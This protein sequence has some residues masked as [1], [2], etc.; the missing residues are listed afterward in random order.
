MKNIALINNGCAKNL[1]DSELMLGLLA[2]KGYNITLDETKADIVI[3]NTCSFIHD[4]EKESIQDILKMAM[5]GKKVI[6]TGCLPQKHKMEL[7]KAIPEIIAMLGTSD[8][9]KV[10]DVIEKIEKNP[11][12]FYYEVSDKPEY[13]YPE[14]VSRQ[15]ITVGASSYI[16]I[17]DGCNF[18]CGYCIIPQ[19]RGEYHSRKIEDIVE[20]AKKL[21]DKGVNEIILIAQDTTSYGQDLSGLKNQNLSELI[22]QL[23]KIDSFEWIRI[24]YTYPSFITDEL[25]DIINDSKKVVNYIDMPIQHSHPEVLKSMRRPIIDYRSLISKIRNKVKNVA[26]RTTFIVGYP[27]ETEEQFNHLYNFVNDIK[28]DKLGVFKYSKEENTFAASLGNQISPYIKSKRKKALMELQQKISLEINKSLIGKKIPSIIETITQ[29]NQIIGRT[30]RDAP[31]ID[32]QIYINNTD[33]I[34][35]PGDIVNV[36]VKKADEYDLWGEII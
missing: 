19:L 33:K 7:K 25:L 20:E 34:L 28:F 30:Y 1:V 23:D 6:V 4:A 35:V 16:K 2:D 36:E 17:A 5:G 12:N 21:G 26:L 27:G 18:K 10:I 14:M 11:D 32:G 8:L 24:M 3:V 22:K 29:E 15:Q 13:I 9:S 31:E